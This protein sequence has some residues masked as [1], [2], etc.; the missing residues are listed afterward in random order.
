MQDIKPVNVARGTSTEE[1]KGHECAFKNIPLERAKELITE[2]TV[3]RLVHSPKELDNIVSSVPE[4][5]DEDVLP[6]KTWLTE[7]ALYKTGEFFTQPEIYTTV[8]YYSEDRLITKT[9]RPLPW[10]NKKGVNEGSTLLL[11]WPRG[12]DN[13]KVVLMESDLD[14][15]YKT[16]ANIIFGIIRHFSGT[17]SVVTAITERLQ[18]KSPEVPI[19]SNSWGADDYIGTLS[20]SRRDAVT[21]AM[22]DEE[23]A[24]LKFKHQ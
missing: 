13:A 4:Q 11:D 3:I 18:N 8:L 14:L 12:S 16:I 24:T 6:S 19:E 23:T 17:S 21:E 20:I 10:V 2:Q 22:T 1:C 15:P 9:V 7:V 5:P